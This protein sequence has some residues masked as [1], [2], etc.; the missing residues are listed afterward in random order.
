MLA[1]NISQH[2]G[3][4]KPIRLPLRDARAQ[5]RRRDVDK[6][7]QRHRHD[8]AARKALA[9]VLALRGEKLLAILFRAAKG[10]QA[11]IPHD[12]VRLV[13]VLERQEHVRPHQKP[14]LIVWMLLMQNAQRVRGVAL[15]AARD[16]HVGDRDLHARVER[17]LL[18]HQA[19]HRKAVVRP[20]RVGGEH[21]VRRDTRRDEQELVE[22]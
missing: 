22:P 6:V 9:E 21:L 4:Q 7:R 14:Q 18:A 13:P 5:L 15:A 1:V 11:R 3:G 16:L 19:R 8:A 20:C 10:A 17:D 2:R 12:L